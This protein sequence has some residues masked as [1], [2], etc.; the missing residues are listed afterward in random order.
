MICDSHIHLPSPDWE[1]N[2]KFCSFGTVSAALDYLKRAGIGRA[3]FNTWQG[4]YCNSSAELDAGNTEVLQWAEREPEFLLPGAVI[5][6]AYPEESRR[7]LAHF[8]SLGHRWVGELVNRSEI[9]FDDARCLELFAECERHD[10]I[11]QLHGTPEVLEVARRFPKLR[12][13]MSHIPADPTEAAALPNVT[14]DISGAAGGLHIGALERA[15]RAFGPR[16]LLF[17]TDFTGY[18]P[19]AFL[20]R[21][22]VVIPA[23]ERP[24]VFEHNLRRLLES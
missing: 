5:H 7:W 22:R 1:H 8:L 21:V 17:G 16:R 20:A 15:Y 23:R 2:A 24:W 14:L 18:E 10:H 19:R 9:P 3:V 6:P 13:V 4:V 12:V 11:V